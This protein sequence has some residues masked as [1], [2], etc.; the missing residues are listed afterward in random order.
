MAAGTRGKSASKFQKLYA[1]IG[2]A[3]EFLPSELPT[4]RQCLQY[5]LFIEE[6]SIDDKEIRVRFAEVRE[7]LKELW[8]A[9][10][11]LLPLYNDKS[12]VDHLVN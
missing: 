9:V 4:L 10:N 6:R 12:I 3:H 7:K 5:N 2:G 11:P 8:L 1:F